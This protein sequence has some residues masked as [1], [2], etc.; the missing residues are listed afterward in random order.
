[1]AVSEPRSSGPEYDDQTDSHSV[2]PV[3]N[4]LRLTSRSNAPTGSRDWDGTFPKR[5]LLLHPWVGS[6]DQG[7]DGGLGSTVDAWLIF[8][9]GRS[10]TGSRFSFAGRGSR[11]DR[12]ELGLP[13]AGERGSRYALWRPAGKIGLDL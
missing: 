1:V 6:H 11:S 9:V 10:V 12:A 4:G 8:S 2:N 3:A 5:A 13:L 7:P